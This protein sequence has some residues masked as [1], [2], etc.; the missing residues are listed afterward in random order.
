MLLEQTL[1]LFQ[2]SDCSR[3]RPV[4][5]LQRWKDRCQINTVKQHKT[6]LVADHICVFIICT[7]IPSCFREAV[8]VGRRQ[9]VVFVMNEPNNVLRRVNVTCPALHA[10]CTATSKQSL[11]SSIAI[12]GSAERGLHDTSTTSNQSNRSRRRDPYSD[13][14]RFHTTAWSC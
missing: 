7:R 3:V 14:R 12:S 2:S 1:T 4:C 13:H 6:A 9:S 5:N 10:I 11:Q 8:R